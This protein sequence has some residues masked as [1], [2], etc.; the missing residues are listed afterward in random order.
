MKIEIRKIFTSHSGRN[1]LT[2]QAILI[3]S[4]NNVLNL[5][6][7]WQCTHF[8]MNITGNIWGS[9]GDLSEYYVY[10]RSWY[11]VGIATGHCLDD[12]GIGVRVPVGSRIFSSLPRPDRL[13]SPSSLPPKGF[14]GVK[15]SRREAD[16]SPPTSAEMKKTWLYTSAP[17]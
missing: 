1:C 9:H 5:L 10:C 12:R 3:F 6:W 14:P 15:R 7:I 2:F 17:P 16:H 8:A 13:W 11:E 4:F